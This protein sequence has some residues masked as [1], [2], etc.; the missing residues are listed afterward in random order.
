MIW[1]DDVQCRGYE[2]LLSS[3]RHNGWGRHDC[4]HF[5]DAGVRCRVHG[6][7]NKLLRME[8]VNVQWAVDL[9]QEKLSYYAQ[10]KWY[11]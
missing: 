8:L 5:E 10:Q 4:S 2:S 6:G 11:A 9:V 1:L 3:C 7:K